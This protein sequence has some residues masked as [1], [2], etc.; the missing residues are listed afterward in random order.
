MTAMA[1]PLVPNHTRGE[2][3][4]AGAVLIN[5]RSTKPEREDARKIV[6]EW[7]ACHAY[8]INTFQSTL[9]L[10][11]K[12]NNHPLVAQRLKR[13]P[14]I[15]DKLRRYPEMDLARMQDIGGLRAVL[16]TLKE[17]KQLEGIYRDQTRFSHELV[18][19]YDYIERPKSD[20][21]R[22][23]HLIYKYKNNQSLASSTYNGLMLE[24]QLRTYQEHL[25]ATAVETMGTFLG[26]ALKA[27]QGDKKWL[28]FFALTSSAFAYQE[29]T[30]LV[31]GYKKWSKEKTFER[32]AQSEKKLNVLETLGGLSLAG[33]AIQTNTEGLGWFY[34]LIILNSENHT[35]QVASYPKAA[36]AQASADYASAEAQADNGAKIEPVLVAAGSL[37]NLKRAYPNYFLDAREFITK[38]RGII[39]S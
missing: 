38:V 5:P 8:P 30:P 11:V 12:N 25:W 33:N 1:F 35:V 31:P 9:R 18:K 37:D 16:R 13:L 3:N 2:I 7:R 14:S 39:G 20:G 19:I 26:Q 17:V 15:I 28:D 23:I 4:R 24:L 34:H 32:V 10:K 36:L 27:R 21:Y 22:G 29:G 6:S